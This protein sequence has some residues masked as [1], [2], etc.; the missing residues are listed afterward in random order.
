MSN[1]IVIGVKDAQPYHRK[2]HRAVYGRIHYGHAQVK[3]LVTHP[4]AELEEAVQIHNGYFATMARERLVSRTYFRKAVGRISK[5]LPEHVVSRMLGCSLPNVT[6]R[7]ENGNVVH[8]TC[9]RYWL[10]P[11]C[12]YRRLLKTYCTLRSVLQ[13]GS[14]LAVLRIIATPFAD[15]PIPC[16]EQIDEVREC[17]TR[18][19]DS[20]WNTWKC[21]KVLSLP[22]QLTA[23]PHI[24]V[25]NAVI[26]ALKEDKDELWD[27]REKLGVAGS[28]K[29]YPATEDALQQILAEYMD[30]P[31]AL[32]Y[33][34]LPASSLMRLHT[35]FEGLIAREHG[36]TKLKQHT[37]R[38]QKRKVYE[39]EDRRVRL[40][41]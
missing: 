37:I 20:R 22:R 34:T 9:Q 10:C 16:E 11:G 39:Q 18:L 6:E 12:W 8:H 38:F 31:P 7:A 26:V 40:L 36:F 5:M 19:Y 17:L 15:D 30:Y 41:G 33:N 27:A 29:Y 25:A 23:A 2:L 24:W 21:D 1:V 4:T 14:Q 35:A 32:L 3:Q 28:W 13:Y